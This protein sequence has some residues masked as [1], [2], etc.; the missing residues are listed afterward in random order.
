MAGPGSATRLDGRGFPATNP[1]LGWPQPRAMGGR[2]GL[3]A[4][5]PPPGPRSTKPFGRLGAHQHTS[6]PAHQHTE[7]TRRRN[8]AAAAGPSP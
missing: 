3:V 6:T 2:R 1:A 5:R 8:G 7:D 4:A